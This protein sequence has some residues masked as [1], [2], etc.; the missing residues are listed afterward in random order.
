MKVRVYYNG[1]DPKLPWCIDNG[2]GTQ[3]T[4]ARSVV[5]SVPGISFEDLSADNRTYPRAWFEFIEPRV[6]NRNGYVRL[7]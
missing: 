5:F 6:E 1:D 3:V 7:H 2:P 4:Y